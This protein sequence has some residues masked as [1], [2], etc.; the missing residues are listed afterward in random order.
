MELIHNDTRHQITRS[1][2]VADGPVLPHPHSSTK[3]FRLT[4][5]VITFALVGKEWRPQS[6]EASG[7]VLKA[8]GTDS[9]TTWGAHIHGWK[10]NSDWAFIHKIIEG[11]RPT[12]SATL[13]FGPFDLEN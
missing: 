11:L 6:V 8:D 4:N 7:P 13:P 1:V 5:L 9:K 2:N 10:A 3:R 12:G